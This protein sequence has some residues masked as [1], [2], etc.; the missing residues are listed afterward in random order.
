LRHRNHRDLNRLNRYRLRRRARCSGR[1]RRHQDQQ[2]H[3]RQ[4][5]REQDAD[6]LPPVGRI[7]L[8]ALREQLGEDRRGRHR[9][10]AAEDQPRPPVDTER[11]GASPHDQQGSEHLRCA[12]AKDEAAHRD[13]LRQAELEPDA[14]HQEYH[15]DL[16]QFARFRRVGNPGEGI[17]PDGDADDEVAQHRRQPEGAEHHHDQHRGG[18]KNEDRL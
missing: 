6:D 1:E 12:Q 15:A 14:E 18:E 2:R 9:Q 5:L 4:V 11:G 17:R 8:E 10:H 13:Q 3:H 7:E 16:R